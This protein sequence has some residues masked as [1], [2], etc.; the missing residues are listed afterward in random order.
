MQWGTDSAVILPVTRDQET[1]FHLL[2]YTLG[3]HP[4]LDK[5]DLATV[6]A[7]LRQLTRH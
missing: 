6:A 2:T 4:N 7:A 1:S 3:N 5:D